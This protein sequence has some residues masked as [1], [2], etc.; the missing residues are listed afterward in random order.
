MLALLALFGCMPDEDDGVSGLRRPG[1]LP[2]EV[3]SSGVADSGNAIALWADCQA[4]EDNAL[5]AWCEVYTDPPAAVEV[6]FSP[7]DG[8]GPERIQ[9]AEAGEAAVGLYTMTEDRE[10]WWEASTPDDPD[11]RISG[12]F[13]TGALPEGARIAADVTGDSTAEHFL[14][15]SPCSVSGYAVVMTP[16]GEVVWYQ[17]LVPDTGLAKH[18]LG[19]SWTEDET[20]LGVY[21]QGVVEVDWMGRERFAVSQG[22]H[23]SEAVHH[24]AFKKDGRVYVLFQEIATFFDEDFLLDGVYVFDEPDAPIA[25]WRIQDVFQPPGPENQNGTID[26]THANS[27]FVDDQGD[28]LVSF[29]HLSSVAKLDGDGF[30]QLIWRLSGESN[31]V[32]G[33]DFALDDV[34]AKDAAFARQHNAHWLPDGRLAMFDNR[35][36]VQEPSRLIVLDLDEVAMTAEIVE[37]YPLDQH[38]RFQGGAWHTEAGNP[39]ATCAPYGRA[40]EFAAGE[41][42]APD[43]EAQVAC[44]D[45]DDAYVPRFV[46]VRM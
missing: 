31:T 33:M 29:R 26:Y 20:V 7:V 5:R 19:V 16:A 25:E 28:I 6:R 3:E 22:V 34:Q 2:G 36:Q 42:D 43:Y 11:V 18:L 45:G 44:A 38:C 12:R 39:V 4:A 27:L 41:P 37:T 35:A 15:V 21:P 24:D 17:Q 1:T 8:L 23:F 13:T 46:P 32:F 10:Y 14:I 40:Y 9:V 30:G